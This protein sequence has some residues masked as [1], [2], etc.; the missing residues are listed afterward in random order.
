[1]V[2]S[3]S[4]AERDINVQFLGALPV[5]G[6]G[7][8]AARGVDWVVVPGRSISD[9]VALVLPESPHPTR[10]TAARAPAATAPIIRSI[11]SLRMRTRQR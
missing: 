9:V 11:S 6:F 10:S 7:R 2:H 5:F 1:M 4:Y 3:V 8:A